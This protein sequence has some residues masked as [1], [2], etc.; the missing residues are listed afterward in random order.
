MSD[1]YAKSEAMLDRARQ[2]IPLASQT[3]SKSLTQY[4]HGVSPFFV[5][6]GEGS[7]VWDVDGNE[8]VDFVNGLLSVMLGY[9]DPDVDAAVRAQME[10]GVTFS[11][12]HPV[13]HEVAEKIVE[14]VPSAEQVRFGKNGSDATSGAVR[15]ARAFTGRDQVVACG[16]HGWH[17]WYIG[18]TTRDLGVPEATRSLTHAVP[19]NDLDALVAL[20]DRHDSDIA[21]VIMEP[22]NVT[23]PADGYLEGV[24]ALTRDR[25]ALLVFDEIITGF[26]FA[27]GGAQALFGIDPDLTAI[28]KGIGNGYAVAAVAGRAD[29]MKLMEEVFYSF[30]FGGETVSL[31]ATLAVLRKVDE[32]D[33]PAIL[34]SR[35]GRIVEGTKAL[36]EK[37]AAG[38]FLSVSGHPAWSFLNFN[39][40][41]GSSLLEIKS[42]WM[43]EI[44]E[45]GILSLG[46]HNMS[47]AHSDADV[48][49]LLAVYDE[50]FPI[51]KQAV[52]NGAVRQFLRCEPLQP[53]FRV[54]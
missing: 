47:F 36:I 6:R 51:L 44:F 34:A 20:F 3:Y 48:D 28:G 1:R 23:F 32:H 39:D 49:R 21:C 22:M 54:R 26:R 42:L 4:P 52:E 7:H 29:A 24:R 13:E 41:G 35:G 8:Y 43:Q 10:S 16:Y 5:Q 15:V 30:T 9:R 12:P 27:R 40:A 38:D 53:L 18:S 33:V 14:M 11:L 31:A 19:Y 45:R 50:V 17:D 25:G 37:H 46:T 2:T